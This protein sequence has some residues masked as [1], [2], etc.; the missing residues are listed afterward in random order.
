MRVNLE[1]GSTPIAF[2]APEQAIVLGLPNTTPLED[3]TEAA[4]Q[5]LA[6]P[7][8]TKAFAQI[9]QGKKSAC[10][11]VCDLTR[12]VP[13]SKVIP[14]VLDILEA[15]GIEDIVI[16][17][18]T[19]THR[20]NLGDEITKLLAE[21]IPRRCRVVNHICTE[22]D[23]LRYLGESRNGVPVWINK[24]YLDAEVRVTIGMIEPHF[25]AGYAG[26]RKMVMPG[27]AGLATV[28]AW[29]SPR[30]LEHP[31][32]TNGRVDG[33]PVHEES[34]AIAKMAP[35]D[36]ILDTALDSAKRP[37]GIFAGELHEAW[38]AGVAFVRGNVLAEVPEA[39][40]IVIT[41]GGGYPLDLTFYQAVK[42]MVGALPILKTGGT[43]IIA[44]ACDE[45]IGNPHFAQTL[46]DFDDL[47]IFMQTISNP[48]WK[49]VADQWQV[50]ELAKA[51]RGRKIR[52]VNRGIPP[53]VLAEL[54]V[55]PHATVEEA[56]EAAIQEHGGDAKIVVIPKGPYVLPA[57]KT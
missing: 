38:R 25:M 40:D 3:V 27:I 28:Q 41:S 14:P 37:C 39:V 54:F 21:D 48:L 26:G 7:I 13:N 55:V 45:G 15:E 36:L 6:S 16:L 35:P 34:L 57:L 19:G 52:M 10:I 42:G 23:T 30:F 44:S 46:L 20:P 24:A 43:I 8:G 50:E 18:A 22:E 53:E 1:F 49:P 33:N 11:V 56:L 29:H 32:A 47:E 51:A 31:N 12:P 9:V 5:A 2:N 17:I 4:R